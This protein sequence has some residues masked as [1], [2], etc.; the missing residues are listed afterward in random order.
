[1]SKKD[2]LKEVI[3][4]TASL[5]LKERWYISTSTRMGDTKWRQRKSWRKDMVVKNPTCLGGL[6]QS[7]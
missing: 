2:F 4:G 3:F 7:V 5:A 6:D 1:M